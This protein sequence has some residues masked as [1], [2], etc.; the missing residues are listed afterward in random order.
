MRACWVPL[1]RHAAKID[2][3]MKVLWSD[4]Y[5]AALFGDHE[6][7]ACLPYLGC[8]LEIVATPESSHREVN[9]LLPDK[10]FATRGRSASSSESSCRMDRR[11]VCGSSSA[12][13]C[14]SCRTP[15]LRCRV[16]TRCRI[17][18]RRGRSGYRRRRQARTRLDAANLTIPCYPPDALAVAVRAKV[19]IYATARV[20]ARAKSLTRTTADAPSPSRTDAKQSQRTDGRV[21]RPAACGRWPPCGG[22]STLRRLKGAHVTTKPVGQ[23]Q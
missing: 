2:E 6:D 1:P 20:R 16:K 11:S 15:S 9:L 21:R 23:R 13:S 18:R 4:Y 10:W 5:G 22:R 14:G 7:I 8:R 17:G 12:S 3:I 19:P